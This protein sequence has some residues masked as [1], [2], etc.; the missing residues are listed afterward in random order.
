MSA[1]PD[2]PRPESCRQLYVVALP[3]D[4]GHSDDVGFPPPGLL[5]LRGASSELVKR[6]MDMPYRVVVIERSSLADAASSAAATRRAAVTLA[7]EY[8]GVAIDM[9]IPQIVELAP[10]DISI[11]T[12]AQ[13]FTFGYDEGETVTY[14]L[15]RF[16]LPELRCVSE[17]PR[18]MV[19]AV[20]VGLAHRLIDTWPAG[21]P[22]GEF[23][24]T[25]SDI[26]LGYGRGAEAD[27]ER[28]VRVN[29]VF[30]P[31]DTPDDGVLDVT[32]TE[33]PARTLFH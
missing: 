21:E 30:V 23:E 17:V 12:S 5:R 4:I 8:D 13:W 20:L 25:L 6:A 24:V 3:T 33:D 11:E 7:R 29:V 26:A 9:F 10:E 14:G 1:I 22:T 16:G 2:A 31:A 32:L 27:D 15:D 18:S 28:S 19:D